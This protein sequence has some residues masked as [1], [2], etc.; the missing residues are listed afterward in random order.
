MKNVTIAL[1]ILLSATLVCSE[2]LIN[3]GA[4]VRIR[5]SSEVGK[6]GVTI[7]V[8]QDQWITGKLLKRDAEFFTIE[9]K[10]V[11]T[12]LPI[13]SLLQLQVSHGKA[14]KK[15]VLIGMA[16]GAAVGL[17]Y[18]AVETS[19]CNAKGG[20]FCGLAYGF[21]VLTIP[22]GAV[23]GYVA[24]PQRWVDVPLSDAKGNVTSASRSF[25]LVFHW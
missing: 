8:N 11:Q 4:R 21:T 5:S 22:A 23:I 13:N 7:S 9:T 17:I 25:Q 15:S 6:D 20:W 3:E 12:R 2:A 14:H 1:C 10:G 19:N 24:A 18:G 16:V